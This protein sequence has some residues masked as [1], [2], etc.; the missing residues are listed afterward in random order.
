MNETMLTTFVD[1]NFD[2]F[3]G[4]ERSE[5]IKYEDTDN[6]FN[7]AKDERFDYRGICVYRVGEKVWVENMNN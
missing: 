4:L 5:I 3:I 6:K 7:F 1:A 2:E